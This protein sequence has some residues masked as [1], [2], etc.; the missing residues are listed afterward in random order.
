MEYP[1]ITVVIDTYNYGRYIE[2][3]I[4][5]VLSQDFPPE[6]VQVMVVDDGST[7][8]TATV[9]ESTIELSIYKKEM[10]D[11]PQRSTVA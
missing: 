2:E 3:A 7:D 1:R 11:R 8:D 4:Q 9:L 6:Q 10:E 5:S